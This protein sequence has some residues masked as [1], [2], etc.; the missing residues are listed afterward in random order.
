MSL[1]QELCLAYF[2]IGF[3]RYLPAA[4]C[5][6]KIAKYQLARWL[7]DMWQRCQGTKLPVDTLTCDKV[8]GQHFARSHYAIWQSCQVNMLRGELCQVTICHGWWFCQ[9]TIFSVDTF[10]RWQFVSWHFASWQ[11]ASWQFYQLTI[12]QLTIK[13]NVCVPFM[14]PRST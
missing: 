6:C 13:I 10:A 1:W 8:A 12:C 14:F 4:S 11:S 2:K 7:F 9:L 5:Q 3:Y